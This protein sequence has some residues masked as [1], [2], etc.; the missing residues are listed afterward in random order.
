MD[1]EETQHPFHL[2]T[3]NKTSVMVPLLSKCRT[4][5]SKNKLDSSHP[6]NNLKIINTPWPELQS[7]LLLTE[8]VCVC[9]C[10][11]QVTQS[12]LCLLVC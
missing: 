5:K 1:N 3:S 9:L 10:V 7:T 4:L 2:Y 11:W 6:E 8:D 12:R